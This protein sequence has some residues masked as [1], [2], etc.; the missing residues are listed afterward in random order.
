MAALRVEEKV[1]VPH[2]LKWHALKSIATRPRR[3]YQSQ[4]KL[5]PTSLKDPL[6]LHRYQQVW[7][8]STE[9]DPKTLTFGEM[10]R[11]ITSMTCRPPDE[12]QKA[13]INGISYYGYLWEVTGGRKEAITTKNGSVVDVLR[14][15]MS[16]TTL[17]ESMEF[18]YTPDFRCIKS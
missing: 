1:Y 11:F 5:L 10:I 16:Y 3:V 7:D 15:S 18:E 2:S 6:R 14:S 4:K 12:L 8:L 13:V 9:D 17:T